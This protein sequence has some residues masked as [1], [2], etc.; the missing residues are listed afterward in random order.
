MKKLTNQQMTLIL[1][2]VIVIIAACAYRFGYM[3][4]VDKADEVKTETKV[5]AARIEEL[6]DKI[7]RQSI[8]EGILSSADEQN[9]AI[10]SKYNA[11][12]TPE[13]SIMFVCE[14]EKN[15]AVRIDSISFGKDQPVFASSATDE[16]GNPQITAFRSPV[17]V[18][19]KA[20]YQGLKD[21][22]DFINKHPERKNV[23]NLM[24][25]YDSET[26]LLIGTLVIDE[27]SVKAEGRE[28]KEPIVSGIEIGTDNIFGTIDLP[29]D[30]S[31]DDLLNLLNGGRV[32]GVNESK[33]TKSGTVSEDK[34][35]KDAGE[36]SEE[37]SDDASEDEGSDDED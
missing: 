2:L 19:F 30:A 7:T 24:V 15:C 17:S 25:S 14:L 9:D 36:G 5:L 26:G 32:Q 1:L 4:F 22:V 35:N 3:T 27:Y 34:G 11:G 20:T 6:N 18:D 10:L 31:I 28:Y 12:N 33:N 16:T 8:Y 21:A 23:D 37:G 13:K 29:A